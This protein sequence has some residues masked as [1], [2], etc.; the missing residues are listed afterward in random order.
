MAIPIT[1]PQSGTNIAALSAAV[2]ATIAQA[3]QVR[4][5]S[6]NLISQLQAS[7]VSATAVFDLLRQA[8]SAANNLTSLAQTPGL[9]LMAKILLPT[10]GGSLQ[11]DTLATVAAIQAV[12]NWILNNIPKD[13]QGFVE[14][15]QWNVDGTQTPRQFPPSQTSGL[16]AML[17]AL[18]ATIV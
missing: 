18:S 14:V 3:S 2:S 12:S 8:A 10:Y 9:D 16:V 11:A 4:Q 15:Y 17:Q 6:D 5:F 13:A 1:T 7:P